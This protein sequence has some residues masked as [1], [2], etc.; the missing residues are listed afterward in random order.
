[1]FKIITVLLAASSSVLA[2]HGN[3]G[4]APITATETLYATLDWSWSGNNYD[5]KTL[6]NNLVYTI[7]QKVFSIGHDFEIYNVTGTQV[8][9]VE[10]KVFAWFGPKYDVSYIAAD[11]SQKAASIQRRYSWGFPT[12]YKSFDITLDSGETFTTHGDILAWNFSIVANSDRRTVAQVDIKDHDFINLHWPGSQV[13]QIDTDTT[14]ISDL[15]PMAL[16]NI[17][18]WLAKTSNNW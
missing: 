18:E 10:Q 2:K 8:A 5:I 16:L 12:A 6:E 15:F 17:V 11:G 14:R 13:Y 4:P 9:K 7:K 1:M 3:P